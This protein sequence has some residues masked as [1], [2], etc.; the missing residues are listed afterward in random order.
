MPRWRSVC[1]FSILLTNVAAKGEKPANREAPESELPTLPQHP[2][3]GGSSGVKWL[4]GDNS[5]K[6]GR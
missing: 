2:H 3:N 6:H 4:S 5:G 1:F